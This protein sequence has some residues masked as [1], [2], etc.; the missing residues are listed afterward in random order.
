MPYA[1]GHGSADAL[2]GVARLL[3]DGGAPA[4][5]RKTHQAGGMPA[6]LRRI[7]RETADP[8]PGLKAAAAS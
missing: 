5:H 2:E 8:R 4:R 7:A 6:L 3:E 1:R